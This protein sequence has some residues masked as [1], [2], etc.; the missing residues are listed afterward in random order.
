MKIVGTIIRTN[1]KSIT[2]TT[3]L[4][5]LNILIPLSRPVALDIMK[6]TVTIAM[7]TICVQMLFG[8]EVKC[9]IP[10]DICRALK[11][12]VV[13]TPVQVASTAKISIVRSEEHTSE[14]QS[15][16]HVV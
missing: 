3:I 15:R 16:G 8:I 5:L 13:A 4:T 11:P 12:K 14:L 9:E 10:A 6:Q 1:N 7:I 2:A